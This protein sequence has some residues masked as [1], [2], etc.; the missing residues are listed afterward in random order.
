MRIEKYNASRLKE[1]IESEQY[2]T[3]PV[4]PV[5]PQR[6]FS[7]QN[8]PRM[9]PEDIL[10]YLF[11]NGED[12]AAY[13]CILPDHHAGVRFGWLSGNWVD[14]ER[15][16]QG[17]ASRLFDE[18]FKDWGH[19]LMYTNYAPES[20]AVYD[21]TGRFALY[22]QREGVR[23]Y[24][25]AVSAKLLGHRNTFYRTLRPMFRLADGIINAWQDLRISTVQKKVKPDF[26]HIEPVRSVDPASHDL[27]ER[28]NRL[29]FGVRDLKVFDW[30]TSYPW[31][32]EGERQD[33]RYFF[34]WIVPRLKNTC[35]KVWD[36]GGKLIGFLML[37]V[38]GEKMTLPYV[39]LQQEAFPAVVH[40]L[41]HYLCAEKISYLTT[42]NPEMMGLLE[43]SRT[44]LLGRRRMYQKVFATHELIRQLPDGNKIF[45]QDGDGDV[46]F[47]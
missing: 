45:F 41:D 30:I 16:R 33:E 12:L 1:F 9:E 11:F 6:A 4:I 2:R 43:N 28:H 17:L 47:T 38:V 15:R 3:M 39:C 7:W 35:L 23:Y 32:Q 18:A 19:Q 37:A 10:M 25:R 27:M 34:T 5:S 24:Q 14:P 46:V 21:K 44:P 31:L 29:G 8:N 22:R 42:Y 20:K 26:L 40:I 36:N 13:R